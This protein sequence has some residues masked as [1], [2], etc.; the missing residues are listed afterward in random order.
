MSRLGIGKHEFF[1]ISIVKVSKLLDQVRWFQARDQSPL[2]SYILEVDFRKMESLMT[3]I[4]VLV[5]RQLTN[6]RKDLAVN[7]QPF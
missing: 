7:H 4:L 3:Q 2:H 6:K 1:I 5:L